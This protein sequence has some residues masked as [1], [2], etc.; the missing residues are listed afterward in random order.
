MAVVTTSVDG[1]VL[2]NIP[3]GEVGVFPV[4]HPGCCGRRGR[5]LA[6]AGR[7]QVGVRLGL[8]RRGAWLD[9]EGVGSG[10]RC[11]SGCLGGRS[12]ESDGGRRAQKPDNDHERYQNAKSPL[13][14]I[15]MTDSFRL[16]SQVDIP[17]ANAIRVPEEAKQARGW[18]QLT[19]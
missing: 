7:D 13:N 11:R 4:I 15:D 10:R 14:V 17:P 12:G 3:T 6:H 8:A 2:I 16:G 5:R 18:L 1:L 19:I 9:R